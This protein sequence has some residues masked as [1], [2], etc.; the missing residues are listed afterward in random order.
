MN[1]ES[2]CDKHIVRVSSRKWDRKNQIGSNAEENDVV[3]N[4]GK[5][6]SSADEEEV[7]PY[8]KKRRE[9]LKS[10]MH[11]ISGKVSILCSS[12]VLLVSGTHQFRVSPFGYGGCVPSQWSFCR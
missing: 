8:T 11:D 7:D 12:H 9:S 3:R 4:G 6:L 2:S 1:T 10:Y 5:T